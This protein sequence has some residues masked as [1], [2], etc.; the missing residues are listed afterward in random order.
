MIAFERIEGFDWDAGNAR[1]SEEKKESRIY[2]ENAQ[3][4]P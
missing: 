3:T 1:K 2:E 4:N